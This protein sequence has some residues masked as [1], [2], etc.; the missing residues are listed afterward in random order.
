MELDSFQHARGVWSAPT[1]VKE[2][3]GY[4]FPQG[5]EGH[6]RMNSVGMRMAA[7]KPSDDGSMCPYWDSCI[8]ES[9]ARASEG[10]A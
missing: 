4:I 7:S 2:V 6:P 9:F 8:G 3:Q 10:H 1:D 5:I